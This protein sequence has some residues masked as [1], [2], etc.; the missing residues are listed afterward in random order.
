MP[1]T[2]RR[3]LLLAVSA[4]PRHPG[5]SQC[6]PAVPCRCPS[7]SERRWLVW[8]RWPWPPPWCPPPLGGLAPPP[9]C[10]RHSLPPTWIRASRANRLPVC[11]GLANPRACHRAGLGPA[12]GHRRPRGAWLI[13]PGLCGFSHLPADHGRRPQSDGDRHAGCREPR[14]RLLGSLELPKGGHPRLAIVVADAD[15]AA[16]HHP[17]EVGHSVRNRPSSPR[18]WG[19]PPQPTGAQRTR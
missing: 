1:P 16:D 18:R 10:R 9:P 13:Y 2:G 15:L 7:I 19:R 12:E 14:C 4:F 6:V 11:Q 3:H 8:R 5:A 17:P